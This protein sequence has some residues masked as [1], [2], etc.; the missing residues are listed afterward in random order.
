MVASYKSVTDCVWS[1]SWP[2]T[3]W[4]H[5]NHYIWTAVFAPMVGAILGC[6]CIKIYYIVI[7]H[8]PAYW[9][10]E[11]QFLFHSIWK[12]LI[13]MDWRQ[14]KI[15]QYVNPASQEPHGTFFCSWFLLDCMSSSSGCLQGAQQIVAVLVRWMVFKK[16]MTSRWVRLSILKSI[17]A[18]TFS[19]PWQEMICR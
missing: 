14:M 13:P 10:E 16:M 9:L 7:F 11:A 18:S 1:F 2:P 12:G 17:V 4:T 6:F 5:D 8:H 19:V 3:I 15:K